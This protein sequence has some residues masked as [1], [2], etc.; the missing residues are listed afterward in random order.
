MVM[1]RTHCIVQWRDAL[2]IGS[3]GILHLEKR[4]TRMKSQVLILKP[5]IYKLNYTHRV[6]TYLI[7][8][9]LDEVKLSLQ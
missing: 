2:I 7:D 1:S 6:A 3:A 9:P 8:N 4:E 5:N